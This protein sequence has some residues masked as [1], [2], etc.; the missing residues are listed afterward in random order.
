MSITIKDVAKACGVSVSTVSNILS[1]KPNSFIG[2]KTRKRVKEIAEQMGY[3]PHHAART[4]RNGSTNTIGLIMPDIRNPHNTEQAR[5]FEEAVEKKG[6]RLLVMDSGLKPE[7]ELRSMEEM[8]EQRCDGVIASLSYFEPIKHLLPQFVKNRIPCIIVGIPKDI[9]ALA[10]GVIGDMS[11]GY[12]LA[13]QHLVEL[14]HTEIALLGSYPPGFT[15]EDRHFAFKNALKH[16][17]IEWSEN[18]VL[19]MSSQNQLDDGYAI[20]DEFLR[21]Y[22]T[23]TAA[24]GVNDVFI[25]GVV[26][27]LTE[28]GVR[29]PEDISLVGTDDTW[30]AKSFPVSLTSIDLNIHRIIDE[31]TKMLF[32]R[33][34]EDDW[35]SPFRVVVE[36][37]LKIRESTGPVR[38]K[39]KIERL[40]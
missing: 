6:Y 5:M 40:I 7:N 26:R 28:L 11:R 39:P 33:L 24:I 23:A 17:G 22:P 16:H 18:R 13:I 21:E 34:E 12:N 2:D 3:R 10:D 35:R 32:A 37:G 20:V 30:L 29:V 14:G 31:A 19:S 36:S 9:S 8:L 25:T 4:L 1:D 27:R 15:Q 38:C